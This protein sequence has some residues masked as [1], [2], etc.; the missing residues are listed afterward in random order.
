MG[1]QIITTKH[2]NNITIREDNAIAALEVMSRFAINPKW[3]IYLP[4][5]MSPAKNQ[6]T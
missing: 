5:T 6:R 1:K 2:G 3:L 4:P